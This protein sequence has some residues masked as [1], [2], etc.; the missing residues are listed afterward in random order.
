MILEHDVNARVI[1]ALVDQVPVPARDKQEHS[2]GTMETTAC[3]GVGRGNTGKKTIL[4][5]NFNLGEDI[6]LLLNASRVPG[7]HV[8]EHGCI[9]ERLCYRHGK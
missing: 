6:A 4:S 2:S 9:R 3:V 8:R 1:P 5:P 7:E